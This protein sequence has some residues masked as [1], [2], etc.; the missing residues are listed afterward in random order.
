[1]KENDHN[2]RHNGAVSSNCTPEQHNKSNKTKRVMATLIL[3]KSF[4]QIPKQN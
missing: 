3:T 4:H 1:M 2:E